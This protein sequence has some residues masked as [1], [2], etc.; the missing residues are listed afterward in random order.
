MLE[1][2]KRQFLGLRWLYPSMHPSSEW[3][4]RYIKIREMVLHQRNWA[5]SRLPN[6]ENIERENNRL[7]LAEDIWRVLRDRLDYNSQS[8]CKI[9]IENLSESH[10]W[11]QKHLWH[12]VGRYPLSSLVQMTMQCSLSGWCR[13]RSV[14]FIPQYIATDNWSRLKWDLPWQL[15]R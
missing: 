15:K 13:L 7:L 8:P 9:F 2:E 5:I 12:G 4:A 10:C 11:C 1:W 14:T 6:R 3:E